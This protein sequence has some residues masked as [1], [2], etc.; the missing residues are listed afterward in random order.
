MKYLILSDTHGHINALNEVA[1]RENDADN[2][3]F[4]GDG[5]ADMRLLQAIMPG[6]KIHMV[7][8]NCDFS[9]D[10]PKKIIMPLAK[11]RVL[12]THGHLHEVKKDYDRIIADA[13]E[14]K[15]H[16]VMFGHTHLPMH[17]EIDGITLFNPGTISGRSL[18]GEATYGVLTVLKTK[19][20]FDI[21]N[22]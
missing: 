14:E 16:I 20:F 22:L 21:K 7:C 12:I 8:G 4:L 19:L 1:Q 18:M 3:I 11:K 5:I 17:E 10:A 15:A 2:I 13:K 6:V 9:N